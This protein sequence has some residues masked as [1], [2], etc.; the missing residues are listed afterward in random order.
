MKTLRTFHAATLNERVTLDITES[1]QPETVHI[2]LGC[3]EVTMSR[4]QIEAL[5]SV[6]YDIRWEYPEIAE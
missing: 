3:D 1:F 4:E 2:C 5:K 6:L